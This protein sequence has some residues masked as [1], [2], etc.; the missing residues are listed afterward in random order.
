[1]PTT[2]DPAV[3]VAEA[4]AALSGGRLVDGSPDLE[5]QVASV[6]GWARR[7]C[8][9]HIW[10]ARTEEM[11][12]DGSGSRTLQL[13][14]LRLVDVESVAEERGGDDD[15]VTLGGREFSWSAAGILRKRAGVWTREFRG[16]TATVEHGFDEVPELVG[17]LAKATIRELGSPDGQRLARVGEISYQSMPS[18]PGGAALFAGEYEVLDAYRLNQE[19]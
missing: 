4:A 18:S 14:T 19:V 10:P 1:M 2:A 17:V 8:G 16:V 12:V 9:W 7:Y 15:P 6:L 3:Q 11:I 13:P 5:L